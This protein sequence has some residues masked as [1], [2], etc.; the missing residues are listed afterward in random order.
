MFPYLVGK[1]QISSKV[2]SITKLELLSSLL[3][4]RATFA[5][6]MSED[7]EWTPPTEAEL[8]VLAFFKN[9]LCQLPLQTRLIVWY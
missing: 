3:V 6:T 2:G 1:V 9:L 8:K 4:V 7:E 5:E